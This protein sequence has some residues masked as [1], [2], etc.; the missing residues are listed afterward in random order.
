MN[1]K[2]APKNTVQPYKHFSVAIDAHRAPS[3]SHCLP[4]S[5]DELRDRDAR[6]T[7]GVFGIQ[8]QTL[9]LEWVK[10]SIA[11]SVNSYQTKVRC[12]GGL[13]DVIDVIDHAWNR[14]FRR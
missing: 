8:D 13:I 12:C 9:G 2:L 10:S 1:Q 5:S 14:H 4:R 3:K 11:A 6:K 7:A